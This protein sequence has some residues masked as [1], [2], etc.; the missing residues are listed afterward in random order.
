MAANTPLARDN[1][2]EKFVVAIQNQ[3]L[4]EATVPRKNEASD[5]E[6]KFKAFCIM[7]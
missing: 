4:T 7:R 5:F 2:G 6:N 1:C 3:L